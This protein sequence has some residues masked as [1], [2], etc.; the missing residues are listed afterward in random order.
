MST[1]LYSLTETSNLLRTDGCSAVINE[2][3]E[4]K[5]IIRRDAILNALSTLGITATDTAA[6]E[7]KQVITLSNGNLLTLRWNSD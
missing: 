3:S 4:A 5:A 6:S 2:V 7:R 1:V